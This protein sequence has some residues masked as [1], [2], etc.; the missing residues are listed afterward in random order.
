MPGDAVADSFVAVTLL[1][2]VRV[3]LAVTDAR[4]RVVTRALLAQQARFAVVA[5]ATTAAEVMH[6]ARLFQPDVVLL[7]LGLPGQDTPA[8]VRA[9]R[10]L[11]ASPRVVLLAWDDSD[12]YRD[13][14]ARAGASLCLSRRRLDALIPA[15]AGA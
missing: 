11:P 12:E 5:E 9:L 10:A 8:L 14:A 2:G 15:L 4:F 7:E 1:P 6:S 13:A 3:L